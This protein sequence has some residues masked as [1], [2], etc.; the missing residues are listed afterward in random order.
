MT[1]DQILYNALRADDG[2]MS[3]VG[4]RIVSTCFEVSPEDTDNTEVPCIIVTDDGWQNVN[5]T[6]DSTWESIEDK[7]EASIEVDGRSPREVKTLIKAC[8]TAVAR[9]VSEMEKEGEDVPS[10]DSVQATGLAWDWMK[11]CYHQTLTYECTVLNE[12]EETLR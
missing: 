7:V 10:L 6:K 4:G 2:I 1:L 8:R 12:T 5:G 3:A 9:H 11:P